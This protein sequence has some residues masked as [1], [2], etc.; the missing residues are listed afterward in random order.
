MELELRHHR[1][2]LA[3][4]AH[5]QYG[6]AAEELGITQPTLSRSIQEIERRVGARLFHRGRGGVDATDAGRVYLEQAKALLRRAD[7][8]A[9]EMQ[10]LS[11]LDGAELRIGAGVYP[12]ELFV[13]DA[14]ARLA[15]EHPDMQVSVFTAMVDRLVEML[16][17]REVDVVIG[18]ARSVETLPGLRMRTLAWHRACLV[19]RA[20]HPLAGRRGLAAS[21]VFSHPFAMSTRV[22]PDLMTV[23]LE[24]RGVGDGASIRRRMPSI[25]CDSTS[26]LRRIVAG[27]DTVALLSPALVEHEVARGEL[28]VLDFAAPWLRRRFA[29]VELEERPASPALCAFL[30]HLVEC[31]DRAA[32]AWPLDGAGAG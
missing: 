29:V 19:T 1:H 10:M 8:V 22:P 9:R 18:D 25:L 20:S 11:G 27:S 26:V 12:S 21:E 28:V 6:R 13:A 32:R 17:H 16:R 3:L 2:A 4:S 24:S 5:R 14:V 7:E 30:P 31:D 15:V 23:I